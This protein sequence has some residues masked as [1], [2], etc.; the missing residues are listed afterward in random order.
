MIVLDIEA[1]GLALESFPIEIAWQNRNDSNIYDC[2]LIKPAADWTYWDQYAQESIHGISR[3]LL[4]L[5]GISVLEAANRLNTAL[6]G[7][8]VYTDAPEYDRG[9]LAKLFSKAGIDRRFEV[10][11]VLLLVPPAKEAAFQRHSV[12]GDIVHRALPDVRRIINS[13]NY[14]APNDV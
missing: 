4:E 9:W 14:F 11:D 5:E 12:S 10:R 2:F 8:T 7:N 6:N 1:S 3:E 13:L